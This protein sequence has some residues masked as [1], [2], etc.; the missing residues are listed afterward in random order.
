MFS[1]QVL[2]LE[3]TYLRKACTELTSGY[4]PRLTIIS[5][6]KTHNVRIMRENVSSFLNSNFYV[7]LEFEMLANL[8]PAESQGQSPRAEY[9]LWHCA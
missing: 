5:A 8:F 7:I 2:Q 9:S 4:Y 6:T 1:V 3:T